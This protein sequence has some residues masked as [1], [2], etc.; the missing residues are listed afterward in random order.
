MKTH[1]LQLSD[2]LRKL[3]HEVHI[4][5]PT[6]AETVHLTNF[7]PFGRNF[8][9]PFLGTKID[10]NAALGSE[11][12]RLKNFLK[13][14][15]FDLIHFH[16]IWNPILPFQILS[17]SKTKRVSTF[18]DT[19]KNNWVGRFL[20]RYVM[21]LMAKVIFTRLD[22]IISVSESQAKFIKRY[23]TRKIAI[24]PNGISVPDN[25]PAGSERVEHQLLFLGRLEPRKGIL[26]ALNA[27]KLIYEM[28]P[29]VSLKIAGEG[30]LLQEAK[31]FVTAHSL[32]N[33]EFLGKVNDDQ[34]WQ[35]YISSQVYLATAEY[36]E[37][38]GI[39][40]VEAMS[41]GALLS[42]FAN[43]GYKMVLSN[44]QLEYFTA[45]KDIEGL[46]RRIL[47]LLNLKPE[48]IGDLR[49]EGAKISKKYDWEI[50]V[51]SVLEVYQESR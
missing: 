26:S 13:D 41:M 39:V 35:L 7:H 27:Y 49:A 31:D 17:L 29:T 34:K 48:S 36:G 5:A 19:P 38:F 47:K 23:S 50:L 44:K 32:K 43:D 40:L 4:I 37:S 20:G 24:I 9:I 51:E 22:G 3:G 18:H 6:G 21:P 12:K 1:I 42:G 45:P 16:T 10:I 15:A 46:V 30:D 11:K 25:V 2:A 8:S 33:V 14:E 28:H